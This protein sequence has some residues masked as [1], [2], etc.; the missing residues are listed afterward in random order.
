MLGCYVAYMSFLLCDVVLMW[1]PTQVRLAGNSAIQLVFTCIQVTQ[2]VPIIIFDWQVTRRR[3]LFS[4]F[5]LVCNVRVP[6]SDYKSLTRWTMQWRHSGTSETQNNLHAIEPM[7]KVIFWTYRLP[8]RYEIL[9]HS[10]WSGQ[11][12]LTHT[13]TV[14]T[15]LFSIILTMNDRIVYKTKVAEL[16]WQV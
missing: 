7:V 1:F 12:Y 3:I 8:R 13:G 6:H 4:F 11:S 10:L 2:W 16:N 5:Q 14:A 15:P 9:I